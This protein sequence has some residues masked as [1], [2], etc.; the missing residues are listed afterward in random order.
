MVSAEPLFEQAISISEEVRPALALV[1]QLLLARVWLADGRAGDALD[2]IAYARAFLPPDSISSLLGLCDALEGRAAI[3]AGDL[4]RAEASALRL[5]PGHRASILQARIDIARAGFDQAREALARCV[6]VTLR[7]RLDVAVLAARIACGRN[8]GDAGLLL[9]AAIETARAEG[10][11]V[12]VTDDLT[13]VRSRVARL[14]RS[15]RVGTYEQAV[16]DRLEGGLPPVMA[17]GGDAGTLSDRELTVLRYLASHL[18]IKEIAAEI[19]VSTN[20]VK[21]HVKRIYQARSVLAHRGPRRSPPPWC[22]V[23][24]PAEDP[25]PRPTSEAS[26][27]LPLD[28]SSTWVAVTMLAT[29]LTWLTALAAS[30]GAPRGNAGACAARAGRLVKQLGADFAVGCAGR[31][32]LGDLQFLRRQLVAGFG[33]LP[34]GCQNRARGF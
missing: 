20:T 13:D 18:T 26:Y 11:V 4:D 21:T 12:A 8:S 31:G 3:Q 27:L 23:T 25:A 33:Y 5:E 9:T 16:L 19:F 6:P 29:G 2:G 22:P 30:Q 14:L 7:E 1:S 15:R 32:E 28:R 10:F 34:V 17:H 24:L